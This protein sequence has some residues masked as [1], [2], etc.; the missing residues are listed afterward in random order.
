V[1]VCAVSGFAGCAE[2]EPASKAAKPW[3][4]W[5]GQESIEYYA[6]RADVPPTKTLDLG[7]GVK[8][9]L[10]LIP[11]G[12]FVMGSPEPKQVDKTAFLRK[13]I[14]GQAVLAAGGGILIILVG[15]AILRTIRK[16]H[17]F[18]YS[19]RRFMAMMFAASLCVLG[20]MHW[21]Y[22]AKALYEHHAA[23]AR[24][25]SSWDWETPAHEVTLTTPFYIGK[26]EVTQE[27]YEQV[28][29]LN[30]SY[31]QGPN[32]PVQGVSWHEAH[33]F[34]EKV[35]E[36]ACLT[37]QLPT[38]AQWEHA[39]R[40]G[41]TTAYYTGDAEIDLDRAAWY[42]ANSNEKAHSVGQKTP[43]SWGVYDMHGNVW[44]WCQDW[45]GK[46]A[47]SAVTDPTGPTTETFHVLRGGS[48]SSGPRNCRSAG[49][50]GED[51]RS[52]NDSSG[53]RV[54]VIATRTP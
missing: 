5:D 26:F 12:K 48:W 32:M 33:E 17:R 44:E 27:Q 37:V 4:L 24:F 54:V 31:L 20:G 1:L 40:A 36:K 43:N 49:R 42:Y 25:K 51:H 39:C 23:T 2:N 52:N 29:G 22:S 13:I 10:V 9:E 19:L 16:K 35:S 53:F 34:C 11:A 47:G 18:Q 6:E 15:G 45:Y 14:I 7:N 38:E 28:M 8:L 41:T 50:G 46:Y 3:P 30:R 21:S